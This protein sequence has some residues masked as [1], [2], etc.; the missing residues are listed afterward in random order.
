MISIRFHGRGGQGAVVAS[1]LLANAAFKEG[2]E[3]QSFP[4]FG[5]ERRGAP[6]T[7]FTKVDTKPIRD[8]SE[9]YEPD[10]VIVLDQSLVKAIDVTYGLKDGGLVLV[11]TLKTPEELG[12]KI[13]GKVA[14]VDAN[15][16]AVKHGLGSKQAPI[17]NSAILGAFAKATGLIGIDSL[18]ESIKEDVPALPEENAGAAKD[19]YESVNVR[20]AGE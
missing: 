20:S 9:I 11:N 15:S 3:V 19:A 7:A 6:V 14:T 17:V 10:F 12:L 8:K 16:I 5:V 4:Y 1:S 13:K 2:K 18:V